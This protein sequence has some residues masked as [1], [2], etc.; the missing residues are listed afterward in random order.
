NRDLS[1]LPYEEQMAVR[2][3]RREAIIAL[4]QAGAPAVSAVPDK[5]A[6]KAP[7]PV[8]LVAPTLL[9]VLAGNLQP[10]PSSHEKIEAAI[11]LCNMKH[12]NMPEYNPGLATYLIGQ[13]I[14]DL[15]AEYS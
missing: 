6:K 7:N 12:P 15:S 11:G 1:A 13:M 14:L 8:G 9:K 4:A 5:V 2:F 3:I 10:P